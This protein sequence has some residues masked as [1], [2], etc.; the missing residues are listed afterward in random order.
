MTPLVPVSQWMWNLYRVKFWAE[1]GSLVCTRYIVSASENHLTAD[2]NEDAPHSC[3]AYTWECVK[4]NV[5]P[6]LTIGRLY[7]MP[8][9]EGAWEAGER[10]ALALPR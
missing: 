6:P 3:A 10:L 8:V 7:G 4:E 5:P 2:C 9:S 1:S